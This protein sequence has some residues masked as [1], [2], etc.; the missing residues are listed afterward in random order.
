MTV[1]LNIEKRTFIRDDKTEVEYYAFEAE[2]CGEV[3]SF[4]P[5]SDD[6]KLLKHLLSKCDDL[7]ATSTAEMPEKVTVSEEVK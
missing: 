4:Y 1:T 2:I 3:I 5:K 6:K 7:T